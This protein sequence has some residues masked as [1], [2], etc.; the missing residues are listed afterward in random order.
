MVVPE[1]VMVRR[2]TLAGPTGRNGWV[3][4]SAWIW[5]LSSTQTTIA[6][7]GGSSYS[8][9]PSPTRATRLRVGGEREGLGLPGA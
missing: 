8:P 1:V 7:A 6:W 4:S 3:R 9:T 5:D 2:T